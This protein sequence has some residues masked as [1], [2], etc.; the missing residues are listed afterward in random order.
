MPVAEH[1]RCSC[2]HFPA[3]HIAD[4]LSE[5]GADG[6]VSGA[7]GGDDAGSGAGVLMTVV[8]N[9]RKVRSPPTGL[10]AGGP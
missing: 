1:G 4:V 6:V 7:C 3:P 8:R 5:K 9:S 10:E 2:L